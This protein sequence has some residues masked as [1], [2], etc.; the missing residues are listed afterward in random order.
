MI[1]NLS[2]KLPKLLPKR[3]RR[4]VGTALLGAAL[5]ASSGC[6]EK[7]GPIYDDTF[8]TR[9]PSQTPSSTPDHEGTIV[10]ILAT[11]DARAT[12]IAARETSD[13][14]TE[15]FIPSLTPSQTSTQEST[16]TPRPSRTPTSTATATETLR[17]RNITIIR[18][19]EDLETYLEI[20][21]KDYQINS[22]EELE[23]FLGISLSPDGVAFNDDE[24]PM[25]GNGLVRL[26]DTSSFAFWKSYYQFASHPNPKLI[27][28]MQRKLDIDDPTELIERQNVLF[29]TTINQPTN[30]N[31]EVIPVELGINNPN[32]VALRPNSRLNFE[33]ASPQKL[34][35]V[36]RHLNQVI[37]ST[38]GPDGEN[39]IQIYLNNLAPEKSIVEP[40]N[41]ENDNL[42]RT[43]I[44]ADNFEE[45]QAK[46]VVNITEVMLGSS[47]EETEQLIREATII[48]NHI[49]DRHVWNAVRKPLNA[50]KDSAND[51]FAQIGTLLDGPLE[52]C[53]I[54][55]Q[56]DRDLS[57][58]GADREDQD[59]ML[60]LGHGR[61][62]SKAENMPI[63]AFNTEDPMAGFVVYD[64]EKIRE[65]L[66]LAK[67][68]ADRQRIIEKY[69]QFLPVSLVNTQVTMLEQFGY[70]RPQLY[71]ELEADVPKAIEA[72]GLIVCRPSVPAPPRAVAT[73]TAPRPIIV[74][75][76][77]DLS[78]EPTEIAPTNPPVPLPSLTPNPPTVPPEASPTYKAPD[79]PAT[80]VPTDVTNIQPTHPPTEVLPTTEATPPQ[81]QLPDRFA[82]IIPE[83]FKPN[84]RLAK[85]ESAKWSQ[86]GPQLIIKGRNL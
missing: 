80:V 73:S 7:D 38:T 83:R 58:G 18:T 45:L 52:T 77:P 37:G 51:N 70:E 19:P 36:N 10:A 4:L 11:S 84:D 48:V 57:D 64:L 35:D 72:L 81:V 31:G 78:P 69:M 71:Q 9:T 74:E 40:E 39:I 44:L 15:I 30:Q 42:Y 12:N 61:D 21:L 54:Q 65:E 50:G 43:Y 17:S 27:A 86:V 25:W 56:P 2:E 49:F 34:D 20:S 55:L 62:Y 75:E 13:A 68:T 76:Q 23:S 33:N 16:A 3:V 8:P 24:N 79:L 5:A 82:L 22:V 47:D 60:R 6:G 29:D 26:Q 53:L 67:S 59:R 41:T 63:D 14:Q 1:A 32:F 66:P 46:A 28:D 85:R